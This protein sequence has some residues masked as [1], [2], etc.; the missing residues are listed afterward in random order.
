MTSSKSGGFISVGVL[1]LD[2]CWAIRLD[3]CRVRG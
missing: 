1:A 3:L 2:C